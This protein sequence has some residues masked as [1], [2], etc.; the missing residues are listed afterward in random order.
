MLSI[1]IV[2][3]LAAVITAICWLLSLATKDYSWVDRSWSISP[4]LYAWIFAWPV[5]GTGPQ[6]WRTVLMAILITLW[7][8]RLTFNFARKGGYSGMEDYRW[9]IV[10]KS[11]KGWQWQLFNL[12]F[13]SIYQNV[14]LVLITLPV[15]LSAENP[16]ALGFWDVVFSILFLVLLAGETIADQQQWN[17]QQ[18]KRRNDGVLSPG[19]VT[20]G[21]FHYSRH[22]NF[23]CEQAQWWVVYFM[24][25]SAAVRASNDLGL[26]GGSLNWTLI[27]ALLLTVLFIGSTMM[28]E[29][30]SAR[31]YPEYA[32]YQASTSAIIPLPPRKRTEELSQN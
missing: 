25:A 28:T 4:I 22:P 30:I 19:F 9:A 17:F 3:M 11:M 32:R 1:T 27:G 18:E 15:W 26:L 20:T 2:L 23:F 10:R 29:S 16:S 8:A 24:G 31:R 7:G 14:L 12:F 21:L 13:T 5:L 6:G